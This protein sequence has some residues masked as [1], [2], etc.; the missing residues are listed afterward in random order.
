[1]AFKMRELGTEVVLEPLRAMSCELAE[2]IELSP[3]LAN[4]DANQ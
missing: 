3:A 2:M 4:F 1:M